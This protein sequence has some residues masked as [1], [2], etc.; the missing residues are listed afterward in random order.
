MAGPDRTGI[1][2]S[3]KY[4]V[5]VVPGSD[6]QNL[7]FYDS[8]TRRYAGY[9]RID[10]ATPLEHPKNVTCPVQKPLRRIGVCAHR[11]TAHHIARASLLLCYTVP[12]V[13][14]HQPSSAEPNQIRTH[15]KQ[16]K[17]CVLHATELYMCY[18][19]L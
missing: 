3:D 10:D 12:C 2:F 14:W 5:P 8:H 9:I 13:T 19:T 11:S 6:T 18:R 7:A 15:H 1:E 17:N 16:R 4:G